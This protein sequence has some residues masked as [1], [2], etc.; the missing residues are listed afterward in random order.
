MSLAGPEGLLRGKM[1][2]VN[3]Q[4]LSRIPLNSQVVPNQLL[5]C[6]PITLAITLPKS[7]G[8]QA[9]DSLGFYITPDAQLPLDRLQP[10]TVPLRAAVEAFSASNRSLRACVRRSISPTQEN[11]NRQSSSDL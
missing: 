11:E 6:L 9:I 8:A 5:K 4:Q 2:Y 7:H 1:T 10:A 3:S